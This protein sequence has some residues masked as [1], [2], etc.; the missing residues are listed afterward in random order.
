MPKRNPYFESEVD[1][2]EYQKPQAAKVSKLGKMA[3]QSLF[4]NLDWQ[5]AYT[6]KIS[7]GTAV[8]VPLKHQQDI[9]LRVGTTGQEVPLDFLTYVLF[10]KQKN[11]KMMMELVT[12]SPDP[13]YW[14]TPK[15]YKSFKGKII[16]ETWNGKFIKAFRYNGE[17]QFTRA[18]LKEAPAGNPRSSQEDLDCTYFF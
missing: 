3:R 9:N 11:G 12:W 1:K 10:Y 5:K 17:G 14:D 7:I 4:K 13:D 18:I 2:K 6:R 15:K 16:V 8:I